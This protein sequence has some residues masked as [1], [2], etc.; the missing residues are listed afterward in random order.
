MHPRHAIVLSEACTS[1]PTIN[2]RIVPDVLLAF[3]FPPV[4]WHFR[5]MRPLHIMIVSFQRYISVVVHESCNLASTPRKVVYCTASIG[6]L[7]F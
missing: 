3:C 1:L 4:T 6:H 5:M 2:A 7:V